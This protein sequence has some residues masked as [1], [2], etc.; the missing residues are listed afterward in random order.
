MRPRSTQC[1]LDAIFF[2]SAASSVN[3]DSWSWRSLASPPSRGA[4]CWSSTLSMNCC[5]M[6]SM[7]S[8]LDAPPATASCK[9]STDASSR[10]IVALRRIMSAPI[11][12]NSPDTY[13]CQV[14]TSADVNP[15][16]SDPAGLGLNKD[17]AAGAAVAATEAAA[18]RQLSDSACTAARASARRTST[19]A[20]TAATAA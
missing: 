19:P 18:A 10:S 7:F 8:A 4:G 5:T 20:C 13:P 3:C 16:A 2:Q 9:V 12:A 1:F 17:G 6:A 11:R 15:A 14:S